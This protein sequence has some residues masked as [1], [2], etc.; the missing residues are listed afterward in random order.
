MLFQFTVTMVAARGNINFII[1]VNYKNR[2]SFTAG[3]TAGKN[4]YGITVG[5]S[6]TSLGHDTWSLVNLKLNTLLQDFI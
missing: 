1:L 2:F 6:V 5:N 4:L 3:L